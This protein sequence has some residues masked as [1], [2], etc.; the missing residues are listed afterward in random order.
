M[1]KPTTTV[2]VTVN[3]GMQMSF[4]GSLEPCALACLKTM[5]ILNAE[6]NKV[7]AAEITQMVADLYGIAPERC[8]IEFAQMRTH[9]MAKCGTTFEE[10]LEKR[11]AAAKEE[12]MAK[13]PHLAA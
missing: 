2:W 6:A 12:A 7:Y 11:A 8:F 13:C 5:G 1:G 3:S 9:M 10:I 4:G